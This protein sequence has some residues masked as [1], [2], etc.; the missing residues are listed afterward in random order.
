[1]LILA[2]YSV[3]RDCTFTIG[4][5]RFGFMDANHDFQGDVTLLFA[6]PLGGYYRMPLSA[7]GCLV[8]T[9]LMCVAMAAMA[10]WLCL[11]RPRRA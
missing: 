4:G 3:S 2:M 7:A 5:Q 8:V 1:M 6:G 10:A 9:I 11:R